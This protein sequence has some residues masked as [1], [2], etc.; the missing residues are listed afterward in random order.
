M[1]I[2]YSNLIAIQFKYIMRFILFFKGLNVI[3]MRLQSNIKKQI[4]FYLIK[5][6][7]IPYKFIKG[8]NTLLKLSC[9]QKTLKII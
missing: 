3:N 4:S 7:Q 2:A 6:E 9:D 8:H 1:R 5:T